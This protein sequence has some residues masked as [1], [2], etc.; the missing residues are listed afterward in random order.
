MHEPELNLSNPW[1]WC[2]FD[3][4][5]SGLFLDDKGVP[6]VHPSQ[7]HLAALSLIRCTPGFAITRE[8]LLYVKPE[9]WTM[10]AEAT[11]T[12][13]LTDAF[14]QQHGMPIAQVL[15]QYEQVIRERRALIAHNAGFDLRIM[16]AELRRAGRDDRFATTPHVCTMQAAFGVV[17]AKTPE[18]KPK[19]PRLEETMSHLKIPQHGAHTACGDAISVVQIAKRLSQFGIKLEPKYLKRRPVN[20][21]DAA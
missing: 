6:A 2:A 13:G 1:A 16:R 17:K 21:K 10:Q 9:G 19:P 5:T 14:L 11:E 20:E 18:G 3:T 8:Q 15:D 7:P 12:N 4:E